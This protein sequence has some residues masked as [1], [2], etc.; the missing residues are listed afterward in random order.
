MLY[1]TLKIYILSVTTG[2]T[3]MFTT[4]VRIYHI[5]ALGSTPL[6]MEH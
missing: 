4:D 5:V 1:R 2:S 6:G 3:Y